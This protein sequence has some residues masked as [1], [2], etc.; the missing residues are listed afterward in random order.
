MDAVW[1]TTAMAM[2]NDTSVIENHDRLWMRNVLGVPHEV[3]G[4]G[5]RQRWVE[6]VGGSSNAGPPLTATRCP[7]AENALG[8]PQ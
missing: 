4:P 5:S 6:C 1:I 3:R 7:G 8:S 2:P